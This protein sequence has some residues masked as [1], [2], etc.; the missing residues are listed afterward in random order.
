MISHQIFSIYINQSGS[1]ILFGN[2][3]TKA[4][5][6]GNKLQMFRTINSSTWALHLENLFLNDISSIN[7]SSISNKNVIFNPQYPYLYLP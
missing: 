7:I 6:E 2:Y 4:I 5:K 3:D 1:H